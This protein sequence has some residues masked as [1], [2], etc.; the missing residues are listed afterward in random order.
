MIQNIP[1][2]EENIV[3]D[4]IYINYLIEVLETDLA[5]I[6][7]INLKLPE[8]Y[9]HL[10]EHTLFNLRTDLKAIRDEM[11]R[12][13]IKVYEPM[14]VNEEFMEYKYVVRGYEGSRRFWDAAMKLEGKRRLEKYFTG[15][16][17][18]GS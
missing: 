10:I 12:L 9:L 8:V 16:M 5:Y 14:R 6:P 4:Y 13:S 17:I 7:T 1:E 3:I 15:G 11:K 2:H 18:N